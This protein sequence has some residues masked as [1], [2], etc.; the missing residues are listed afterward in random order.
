MSTA[1]RQDL[2]DGR[3]LIRFLRNQAGADVKALAKA[4]GVSVDTIQR[5]INQIE[6]YRKKNTPVEMELAI[7]DLVIST[8]PE[9]KAAI[10]GLLA[11]TEVVEVKDLRTG[12]IRYRTV[13]DKTTRLEAMRLIKDLI[14]GLQPKG[15]PV[16]VNVNQTNQ[17]AQLTEGVE[18]NEERME[19]LRAKIRAQNALPPEIAGV[20]ASID[21]DGDDEGDDEED[22]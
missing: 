13:D 16:E 21:E 11:A 18:T 12:K 1:T 15:P 9:A 7:R 10:A 5:S 3:H 8:V 2:R 17:V 19:R 22:E 14:I 6:T 4:E 20:P